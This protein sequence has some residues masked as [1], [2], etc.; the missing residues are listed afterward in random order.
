MTITNDNADS[1]GGVFNTGT[2]NL[3]GCAITNKTAKYQG[4]GIFSASPDTSLAVLYQAAM[5]T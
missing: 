3:T 1:G 5:L 2:L 4:G